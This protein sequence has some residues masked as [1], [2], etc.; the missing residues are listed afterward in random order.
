MRPPR[1]KIKRG[2]AV[3]KVTPTGG[4]VVSLPPKAFGAF[5]I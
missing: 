1:A 2:L 5:G 4:Q 3:L